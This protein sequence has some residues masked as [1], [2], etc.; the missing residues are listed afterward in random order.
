MIF[1]CQDHTVISYTPSPILIFKDKATL[2]S[3]LAL[4]Y[5]GLVAIRNL[6]T[7]LNL[8][9]LWSR[10]QSLLASCSRLARKNFHSLWPI[11]S[12]YSL[13]I[14]CTCLKKLIC[15]QFTLY[16]PKKGNF[17]YKIPISSYFSVICALLGWSVTL[18]TSPKSSCEKIAYVRVKKVFE[19]C[20]M[21]LCI[22]LESV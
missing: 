3:S 11:K 12:S 10:T 7:F 17:S 4:H 22:F 1:S 15:I 14:P 5:P 8:L 9:T 20:A 2:H 19:C 18:P 6:I 16:I 21:Y 13:K